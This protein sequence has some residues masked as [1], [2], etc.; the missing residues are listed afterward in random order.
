MFGNEPPHRMDMSTNS[1]FILVKWEGV[2]TEE[3]LGSH[4]IK[5]L[6]RY[7]VGKNHVI[8]IDNFFSSPALFESLLAE[9]IYCCGT[10]HINR[11]GMPE[12]IKGVK[13]KERGDT[14]TVQKGNLVATA[15]KDKKVVAYLITNCDPTESS[16]VQRRKKDGTLQNVSAPIVSD[17]CLV[18]I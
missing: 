1:K 7:L 17:L 3:G 2:K 15:W 12:A 8:Y 9:G 18:L 6:S 16:L 14:L 11:R 10:V 5:D 13:L 4:V